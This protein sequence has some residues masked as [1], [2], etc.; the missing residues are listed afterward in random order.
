VASAAGGILAAIAGRFGAANRA[1]DYAMGTS[2]S[3][4]N[5]QSFLWAIET[6][7]A[8]LHAGVEIDNLCF[9]A[10]KYKHRLRANLNTHPATVAF[11]D[12]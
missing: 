11:L 2:D 4:A 6:A 9:L 3:R 10:F 7:G 12:A 1:R 8:T 5:R